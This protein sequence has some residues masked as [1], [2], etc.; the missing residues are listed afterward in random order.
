MTKSARLLPAARD[1]VNTLVIANRI[2]FDHDVVDAFGHI[3]VRHDKDPA[4]FLMSR[5]LAPGLV[6]AKDIVTFD[7][8]AN[9]VADPA[10]RYYSERFIHSEIYKRRPDVVAVVHCH[11]PPLIPFGA[12]RTPLQPIYHM[13]AYIGA[14]TPVFDIREAAGMTDMLIRTPALGAALAETLA[15]KPLVLMRG[16]GATMVGAGIPQVVYRAIYAKLNAALQMDALKLGTPIYL[17]PEEAAKAAAANDRS[18]E[19]A[20]NLWARAARAKRK[21]AR[22]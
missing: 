7:R 11:A 17:A 13:S 21:G 3:S 8:D 20:W 9:A 1:L 12:T 22:A 10:Q 2:L 6:T 18:L 4:K 19:R 16:H 15:D 14:G 5:H